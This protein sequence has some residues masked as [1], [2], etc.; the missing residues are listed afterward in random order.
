[1]TEKMTK[2]EAI[3]LYG[4]EKLKQHYRKYGKITCS[5]MKDSLIKTLE[6]HYES[7]DE[8]RNGRSK[9]FLLGPK[10]ES[11]AYRSDRRIFNGA[12]NKLSYTDSM[13]V[14]VS[15]RLQDNLD[16][17]SA[18][19]L[20]SWLF[21]FG[22][23]NSELHDLLS[24]EIKSKEQSHMN[25]LN[26]KGILE[27]G[28]ISILRDF[29][30]YSKEL[31]GQLHNCLKRLAKV[32]LIRLNQIRYACVIN[33][34]EEGN[35]SEEV[36]VLDETIWNEIVRK[37]KE[38]MHQLNLNAFEVEYLSNSTKVKA[39]SLR[40]ESYLN[41]EIRVITADGTLEKLRIKYY[42]SAIEIQ[43]LYSENPTLEYLRRYNRN[44]E[45]SDFLADEENF[46]HC[47]KCD[48]MEGRLEHVVE[49]ARNK[50]LK[51]LERRHAS[52]V[53]IG[54]ITELFREEATSYF[55]MEHYEELSSFYDTA[56]DS[57]YEDK[58]RAI[59]ALY[60]SV[61]DCTELS[62]KSTN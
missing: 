55:E 20:R 58:I 34:D 49:R 7:V 40:L 59:Q 5:N 41:N 6:Q 39:F 9:V 44:S 43:H 13:D 24:I 61:R 3:E 56:K 16:V 48:Y 25:K 1:M 54:E 14:V 31:M 38:L 8:V 33:V 22:L 42:W 46:I 23:I 19:T 50:R 52:T 15:S 4:S 47:S 45:L 10:R 36:I 11:L 29:R 21:T 51:A 60:G 57:K 37:R 32:N 2:L 28:E 30:K 35:T 18:Q 53:T 12:N 27:N 62:T 17:S 26:E